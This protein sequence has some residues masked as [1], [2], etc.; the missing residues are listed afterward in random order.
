MAAQQQ[1]P[2]RLHQLLLCCSGPGASTKEMR[3]ASTSQAQQAHSPTNQGSSG[4][5]RKLPGWQHAT[6]CQAGTSFPPDSAY[7]AQSSGA[8]VLPGQ[9]H[10]ANTGTAGAV[11]EQLHATRLSLPTCTALFTATCSER[12]AVHAWLSQ[13]QENAQLTPCSTKQS[14]AHQTLALSAAMFLALDHSC[15][16]AL[17]LQVQQPL[18]LS[19]Y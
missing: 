4:R 17:Q 12:S 8:G 5:C 1:A 16:C 19:R 9:C 7:A 3:A 18:Q 6:A 11:H 15:H 10:P 13:R 2:A 14:H